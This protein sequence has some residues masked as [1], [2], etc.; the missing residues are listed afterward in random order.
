MNFD[1]GL[2]NSARPFLRKYVW[3]VNAK[4]P[5]KQRINEK[6]KPHD[7]CLES[8]INPQRIKSNRG[9]WSIKK[10]VIPPGSLNNS[11]SF[12][13]AESIS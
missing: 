1:M 9:K 6:T 10:P 11:H 5:A 7:E 4:I 3:T 2:L 8:S 12:Q 13:Y